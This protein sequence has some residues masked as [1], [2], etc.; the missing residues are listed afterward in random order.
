MSPAPI[1]PARYNPAYT[2]VLGA[3]RLTLG[4]MTPLERAPGAQADFARETALAAR[5]GALGI[6]ALWTRDVPLAIP[7]GSSG[8]AALLD[9]P[10]V[11]LAALALAAPGTAIG[12]GAAVL[13]LRH[14]L[15]LAKAALSLDRL[16]GGR[17]I[18][19][20]ARATG[21][22]SWP[23]LGWSVRPKCCTA[24]AGRCCAVRWGVR[25]KSARQCWRPPA[26]SC[27]AWPQARAF[28]C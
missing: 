11:W 4:L 6:A 24:S 20:W 10:F 12:L 5:A 21:R 18:L 27:R 3:G 9:D 25:M 19:G 15:H 1:D 14:P 16:S 17:L 2:Q 28:R 13:P 22:K 8:E 7:Q 26:A 23:P